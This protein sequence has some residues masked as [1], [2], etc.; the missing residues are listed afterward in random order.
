MENRMIV[1][2]VDRVFD[3]SRP[4]GAALEA[5]SRGYPSP[6]DL[7]LSEEKAGVLNWA[8]EG[9]RRAW[10]R[11]H[12]EMTPAMA[13]AL[14]EIRDESNLVSKFM[15]D[16]VTMD[17]SCMVSTPDFYAAFESHFEENVER[18]AVPGP[19]SVGRAIAALNDRRIVWGR[20]Y[21]KNMVRQYVGVRLNDMGLDHWRAQFNA[22]A[23]RGS[24]ARLSSTEAEVNQ[25]L[26]VE[27]AS[28]PEVRRMQEE[29]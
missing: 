19:K 4:T 3:P 13:E 17:P 25:P 28:R 22:T 27:W 1:V 10:A 21:R 26:P 5:R 23:Q 29:G 15:R 16:C 18:K 24:S 9:L 12:L 6:A 8:L 14:V 7:V 2:K 11:G 20:D